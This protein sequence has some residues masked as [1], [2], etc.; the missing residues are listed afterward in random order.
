Y[1]L[2]TGSG[3]ISGRPNYEPQCG[4]SYDRDGSSG[5]GAV[6]RGDVFTRHDQ[7]HEAEPHQ[8]E[9]ASAKSQA[10]RREASAEHWR[11]YGRGGKEPRHDIAEKAAHIQRGRYDEPYFQCDELV[12]ERESQRKCER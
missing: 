9:R 3:K 10:Q 12:E 6:K 11:G 1:W 7:R 4:D 8:A 2:H 5:E